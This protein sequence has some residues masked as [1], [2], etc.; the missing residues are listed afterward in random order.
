MRPSFLAA[1][2]GA[3]LATGPA[4]A[5]EADLDPRFDGDGRLA[6]EHAPA[7]VLRYRV[8]PDLSGRGTGLKALV[9]RAAGDSA[10]LFLVSLDEAGQAQPGAI[11]LG[12]D[13]AGLPVA[14]FAPDGRFYVAFQYPEEDGRRV[15]L[16][17][18][19]ADGSLDTSFGGDGR[20]QFGLAGSDLLAFDIAL[21]PAG[22]V[23][24][25][26]SADPL[27][28]EPD[29]GRTFVAQFD[30]AG[31]P[32]SAFDGDGFA[33]HDLVAGSDD[34]PRAAALEAD[35]AVL[36]CHDAVFAGQRDALLTRLRASGPVD[37]SF[38]SSGTLYYDT[39]LPGGADRHD[40]CGAVA[41]QG[42]SGARFMA[43]GSIGI[44]SNSGA[45]R[46]VAVD[47][48]GDAAPAFDT[49]TGGYLPLA[50]AFDAAQR[51]LLAAAV[52]LTEAHV[53][54]SLV[55]Y[56]TAGSPDASFGVGGAASYALPLTAGMSAEAAIPFH[57]NASVDRRGR[58]LL[59]GGMSETASFGSA[60]FALRV[61]G[62]QV[63]AD[64]F[65]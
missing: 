32:R 48:S 9:E 33:V 57:L 31:T 44:A 11:D 3:M 58:I 54:I 43:V 5:A 12:I 24:V 27:G 41:L 1:L 40:Y 20:V 2:L 42:G 30:A 61:L 25:L 38:A 28:D 14:R 22:P 46:L 56:T 62:D 4:A 23:L 51:P 17:R 53:A 52:D 45:V 47:A 50:L 8:L 37:T 36:V 29:L 18:R 65:E 10:R 60:W 35:G 21:D 26:G 64:G 63:H 13:T 55:R 59:S 16:S 19:L 7:E 49:I 34:A 39:S 15:E 6:A